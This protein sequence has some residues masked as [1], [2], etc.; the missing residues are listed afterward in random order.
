MGIIFW[1][2][3]IIAIFCIIGTSLEGKQDIFDYF[4]KTAI[5]SMVACLYLMALL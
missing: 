3:Y 5:L 1:I 4:Y 2:A